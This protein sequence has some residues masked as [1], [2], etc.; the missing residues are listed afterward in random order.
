[1]SKGM[2]PKLYSWDYKTSLTTVEDLC[3]MYVGQEYV[4]AKAQLA[5]HFLYMLI[6]PFKQQSNRGKII[7]QKETT[8]KNVQ[9]N[10]LASDF[11]RLEIDKLGKSEDNTTLQGNC[12]FPLLNFKNIFVMENFKQGKREREDYNEFFCSMNFSTIIV[13]YIPV[14]HHNFFSLIIFFYFEIHRQS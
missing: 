7:F 1:M 2:G 8:S 13:S 9:D 5:G 3:R 14:P 10:L 4:F 6:Y 12:K 11:G